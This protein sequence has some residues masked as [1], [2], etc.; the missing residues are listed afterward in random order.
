MT[1]K[2]V[3]VSCE[4]K[5][6]IKNY[7]FQSR[8]QNLAN[9]YCLFYMPGIT[10]SPWPHGAYFVKYFDIEIKIYEEEPW[11]GSSVHYS[12]DPIAQGCGFHLWW[13]LT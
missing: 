10:V 11:P 5:R 4:K 13:R 7:S 6:E 1:I 3:K 8:D 2:K 9:I 12:I